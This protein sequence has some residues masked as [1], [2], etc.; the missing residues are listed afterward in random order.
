MF[1]RSSSTRKSRPVLFP[2]AIPF[3]GA[4]ASPAYT[5]HRFRPLVD[6]RTTANANLQCKDRVPDSE[7]VAATDGDTTFV[8]MPELRQKPKKPKRM[9]RFVAIDPDSIVVETVP[10]AASK[11]TNPRAIR[12]A[13]E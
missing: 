4:S 13:L 12:A 6:V 11:F 5:E 1:A 3:S 9:G 10:P 2:P 7:T 8:D